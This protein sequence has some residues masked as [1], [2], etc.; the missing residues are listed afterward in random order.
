M[1]N[2]RATPHK[3]TGTFKTRISDFIDNEDEVNDED[4]RK[5]DAQKKEK[6]KYYADK[7]NDAKP[8][9]INIGDKVIVRKRQKNMTLSYSY[10]KPYIVYR[11]KCNMIVARWD[12]CN[13]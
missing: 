8:C 5:K 3:T 7:R 9:N 6:I 4:I 1:R 11:K 10:L 13:N 2:Y 12:C